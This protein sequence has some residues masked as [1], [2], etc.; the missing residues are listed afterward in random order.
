MLDRIGDKADF[1]YCRFDPE[2]GATVAFRLLD[3]ESD[4][5]L[6]WRWMNQPHVVPQWKMAKPIEL[7]ADYI[8]RN[9]EDPHQD[10][11]IGF[12]DGVPMSY[13][14]AYWA[15]EDILGQHYPALE[16]DRGWHMLVGDPSFFGRGFA[17]AVIRAFTR[18]LFLDDPQTAKVVGEPAVS[19]RRLLRYAPECA[20]EEQGEIELPDKRAKLMFCHRETFL[21]RFGI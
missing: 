7:I 14:E 4:T 16:K 2:I 15:K 1:A 19:A 10:P 5:E 12:I 8:E 20:F 13:W 18:F 3:K 6:L 9:L 21:Q 17:P 11:Y